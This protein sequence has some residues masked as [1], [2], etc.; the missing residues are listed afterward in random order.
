MSFVINNVSL[1]FCNFA[2][3]RFDE[4]RKQD[5]YSSVLCVPNTD[6]NFNLLQAE[7]DDAIEYARTHKAADVADHEPHIPNLAAMVGKDY[8]N[9]EINL[10]SKKPPVVYDAY[11]EIIQNPNMRSIKD[12]EVQ[13][14]IYVWT[15][16]K[17]RVKWGASILLDSICVH[18]DLSEEKKRDEDNKPKLTFKKRK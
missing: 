3:P 7:I 9:I 12:A 13:L 11:G 2:K 15:M 18:D 6:E 8:Q 10:N 4:L 17:G 14:F 5:V 16:P 1:K